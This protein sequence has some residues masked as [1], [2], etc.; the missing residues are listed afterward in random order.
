LPTNYKR[1]FKKLGYEYL[2][3]ALLKRALSH[4]SYGAV[5]NERLEFLGDSALNFIIASELFRKFP[6][7]KE[8]DLSRMRA[9]LVRG[10]TLAEI[11]QEFGL[12]E[13]LFLGSGE[14]KSGGHRRES[15]L[16]DTVEALIGAI[17]LEAGFDACKERVLAWYSQRLDELNPDILVHKDAKTRLQE[18]LQGRKRN[19]PDYVLVATEGAQHE[20]TFTIEC[21]AEG[22]TAVQ[23]SASNRKA[24]EQMAAEAALQK[25]EAKK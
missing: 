25:I 12:G 24:A 6:K 15:I 22:L 13:Y 17:L 21:R 4:R 20:Q 7:L 10:T 16:A 3:Q 23:A 5:N 11:A 8:G 14:M 18:W 1:L 2:D 9:T 19:L